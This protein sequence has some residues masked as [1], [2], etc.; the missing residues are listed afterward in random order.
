MT[1]G[2]GGY[3]SCN[4]FTSLSVFDDISGNNTAKMIAGTLTL[5]MANLLAQTI[6]SLEANAT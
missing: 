4:H 2:Q 5:H 6:A 1:A 3:A